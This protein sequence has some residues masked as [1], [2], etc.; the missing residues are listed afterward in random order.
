[1]LLLEKK[2]KPPSSLR[3][4]ILAYFIGKIEETHGISHFVQWIHVRRRLDLVRRVRC[5]IPVVEL[6]PQTQDVLH[7]RREIVE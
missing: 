4:A 7:V 6:R 5:Q 2:K 1:M 3:L